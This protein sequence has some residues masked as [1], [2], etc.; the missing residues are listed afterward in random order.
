MNSRRF[1]EGLSLIAERLGRTLGTYTRYRR[2]P[3]MLGLAPRLLE[4]IR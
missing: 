3:P 4:Q 2:E 1:K